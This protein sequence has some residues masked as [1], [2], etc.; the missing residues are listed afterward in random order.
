MFKK[1]QWNSGVLK[2][3]ANKHD[4]FSL[5]MA[6]IALVFLFVGESISYSPVVYH[7]ESAIIDKS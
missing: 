3:K 2:K 7:F 1:Y 6:L 4:W 5:L